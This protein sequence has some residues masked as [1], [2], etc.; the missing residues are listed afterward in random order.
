VLLLAI[1][2]IPSS[3]EATGSDSAGLICTLTG[4]KVDACCCKLK[5]GK[6]FCPLAK[7]YIDACC[8]KAAD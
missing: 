5:D 3:T 6:L 2:V 4:K 7:T 8:C 1:S